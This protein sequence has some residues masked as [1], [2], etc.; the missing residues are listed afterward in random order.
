MIDLDPS[1]PS[2]IFS[3]LKFVSLQAAKHGVTPI[4][5]FDQPLYWKALTIIRAQSSGTYMKNIILRLGGLHIQMNFMGSIGA[6]DGKKSLNLYMLVT[7]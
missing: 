4:V 1:D 7:R 2:C 3:T 5:T 6:S